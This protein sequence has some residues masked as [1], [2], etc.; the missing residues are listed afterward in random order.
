[1][2]F[3]CIMDHVM[4]VLGPCLILLACT[5]VVGLLYSFFSL[6]LPLLCPIPFTFLYLLYVSLAMFFLVNVLFNYYKCVV[7]K[8]AGPSYEQV[9]RELA[10]ATNFDYPEDDDARRAFLQRYEK[11]M[12]EVNMAN[13]HAAETVVTNAAAD[14]DRSQ[15]LQVGAGSGSGS[16]TGIEMRSGATANANASPSAT[17]LDLEAGG[18][19]QTTALLQQAGAHPPP[20]PSQQQQTSKKM[21]EWM[22]IDP[23]EWSYCRRTHRP[24][25]PRAHYDHV[26]KS[27]VLT[28]DHFCPWMANCVG[29]FNYRYFVNFLLYVF[30]AMVYGV[31]LT[32]NLFF[33]ASS[34]PQRHKGMTR[35]EWLDFKAHDTSLKLTREQRSNVTF[36]FMLCVSVGAAVFFLFA[37]HLYLIFSGQTTIEFHGNVGK[38]RKARHRG[39]RWSNPYDLGWRRNLKQ[40][41]GEG[42][43][44]LAAYM[45]SSREPEFLPVAIAGE[46]GR[47]PVARA[48]AQDYDYDKGENGRGGGGEAAKR[49]GLDASSEGL[50]ERRKFPAPVSIV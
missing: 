6:V 4:T 47:R 11:R 20:P 32:W 2:A 26:S 7:T 28:M 49:R 30:L 50:L 9:V 27:L 23:L 21:P 24:K 15:Q 38:R 39:V 44:T 31:M 46:R 36:C 5:I 34:Y 37:F 48:A 43:F 8:H 29:Y 12:H 33:V 42:A 25:P 45:P 35:E 41:Y 1:M 13:R 10:G 16:G 17:L 3:G 19:G 22:C 40:V 18:S 14:E